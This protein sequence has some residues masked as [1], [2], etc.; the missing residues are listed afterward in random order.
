MSSTKQKTNEQTKVSCMSSTEQKQSNT[1]RSINYAEKCDRRSLSQICK[2][3]SV[4][5][6]ITS[7]GKQFHYII[8]FKERSVHS[9]N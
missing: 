2:A 8:R 5:T 4:R 6:Q 9:S 1:H 3:M 7:T